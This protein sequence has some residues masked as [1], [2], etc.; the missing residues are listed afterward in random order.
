ML[1]FTAGTLTTIAFIPQL[2]TAWISKSTG[3]CRGGWCL[4]LLLACCCG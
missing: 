1:G 3:I 2:A 4:H